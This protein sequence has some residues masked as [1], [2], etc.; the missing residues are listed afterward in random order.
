MGTTAKVVS[1]TT[2]LG[3]NASLDVRLYGVIVGL[4]IRLG[5]LTTPDVAVTDGLTGA[6]V[7][8]DTGL[9]ADTRVIPRV[10]VQDASGSDIAATYDKPVIT[11]TLHVAITGGGA[12]K[13]GELV[14]VYES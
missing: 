7:Y 2:D 4:G 6:E 1:L 12:T 14:I 3:G 10:L 8:S 9:V 5:T 11:G 13:T